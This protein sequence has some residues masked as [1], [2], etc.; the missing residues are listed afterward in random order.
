MPLAEKLF[1]AR[2]DLHGILETLLSKGY[3]VVGPAVCR[4]AIGYHRLS[5][6]RSLEVLGQKSIPIQ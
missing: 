2:E 6:S 1:I 4:G 3:Q 5:F